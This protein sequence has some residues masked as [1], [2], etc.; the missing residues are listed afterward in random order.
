M[1]ESDPI[2]RQVSHPSLLL[3]F[4]RKV[5][6]STPEDLRRAGSRSWGRRRR[7]T[8]GT[9][10]KRCSRKRASMAPKPLIRPLPVSTKLK[11]I[12]L[13]S[14]AA[15]VVAQGQ[16]ACL[17]ML[18]SLV[19][20]PAVQTII[21]SSHLLYFSSVS[22]FSFGSTLGCFSLSPFVCNLLSITLISLQ[23]SAYSIDNFSLNWQPLISKRL[24]KRQYK[25]LFWSPTN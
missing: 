9:S 18:R 8:G 24:F 13:S 23:G 14:S 1:K 15:A 4:R 25:P 12:T 21:L 3:I 16:S 22:S 20:F 11:L 17:R 6:L 5:R 7:R 19:R 10:S 2:I